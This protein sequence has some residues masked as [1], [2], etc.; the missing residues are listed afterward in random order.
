MLLNSLE[1]LGISTIDVGTHSLRKAT[2][3]RWL[4]GGAHIEQQR[5]DSRLK[6]YENFNTYLG[7]QK[8]VYE[9]QK[10]DGVDFSQWEDCHKSLKIGNPELD[11]AA[12]RNITW[13]DFKNDFI[14]R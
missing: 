2:W 7:N 9:Q 5:K 6:N 4:I 8:D 3:M 10:S 12:T 14:I 1:A 13:T 11:G